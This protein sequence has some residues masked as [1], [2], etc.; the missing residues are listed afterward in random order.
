MASTR[1]LRADAERNRQR[2]L[3]AADELFAAKG[4]SVGLDE[5]ARHAGVG[6]ATAYR[7]FPDKSELIDALFENHVARLVA[8]AEGALEVEDPWTGL[9]GFLHSAVELNATNR[10]VKE[11]MFGGAADGTGLLDRIRLQLAPIVSELVRRAQA[12]GD[13]RGDV[14]VTDIALIQFMV[15]G[16]GDLGGP[17]ARGLWH[18][19]LS[20]L[21]D[22]LRTPAPQALAVPPITLPQ[23]V[24]TMMASRG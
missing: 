1:P 10:G 4:L 17:H 12:A 15:S 14:T 24:E 23:Y 7:R 9:V 19:Y 18:R 3:G 21:L 22:G 11:L 5:I 16:L 20:L 2:L 6:V 8:M 13:L